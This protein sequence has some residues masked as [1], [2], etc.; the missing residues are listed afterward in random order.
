MKTFVLALAT[1]ALIACAVI[2]N[3]L[4]FSHLSDDVLDNIELASDGSLSTSTRLKN[5]EKIEKGISENAFLIS[6]TV[7]H[8][9][10]NSLFAYVSDAKR[11]ITRDEGQCLAAIDKLKREIE[12]LKM[13][14]CICLDG[15]F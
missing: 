3:G 6:L 14:E 7:G 13:T 9:E 12:R 8:D 5:I 10:I 4:Y 1:L 11:Q 15:T 2:A